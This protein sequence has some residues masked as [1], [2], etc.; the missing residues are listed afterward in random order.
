MLFLK[1]K[2]P[3]FAVGGCPRGIGKEGGGLGNG[4][5]LPPHGQPRQPLKTD[6]IHIKTHMNSYL[7]SVCY[8]KP[9]VV[10]KSWTSASQPR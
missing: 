5:T 8:A 7:F 3:F 10:Q 6:E 4:Y 2:M 9:T 1:N